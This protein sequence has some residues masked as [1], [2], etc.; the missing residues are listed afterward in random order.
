[1]AFL[2]SGLSRRLYA[3]LATFGLVGAVCLAADILLFNLFAFG[4]GM[5]P[6]RAKALQLVITAVIAFFGHRHVTFRHRHGGGYRREVS[7]FLT[8]TAATV[9]LSL[10]PVWAARH[11]LGITSV[12]GLNVANLIGIGL[13]T[14]VR[15]L[16]YRYV[17]WIHD[18]PAQQLGEPFVVDERPG[19][20][21]GGAVDGLAR[22]HRRG[23]LLEVQDE[24]IRE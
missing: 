12:L 9:L 23:R 13:G 2:G 14:A 8:S 11:V 18:H 7:T 22:E 21:A 15:Y 5:A 16:S 4:L 17:V 10:A 24:L 3:E 19:S 6:V 20:G 1:M